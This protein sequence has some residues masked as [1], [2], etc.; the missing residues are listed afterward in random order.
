MFK[1][2]THLSLRVTEGSAAISFLDLMRLLLSVF[3]L[4]AMTYLL[5]AFVH[6]WFS[7]FFPFHSAFDV[8]RLPC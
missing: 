6:L 1:S 7:S 3:N 8:G 5:C 2:F 4:L